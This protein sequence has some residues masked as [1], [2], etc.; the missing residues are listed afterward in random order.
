MKTLKLTLF[1]FA[2]VLFAAATAHATYS[3]VYDIY[4]NTSSVDGNSGYLYLQYDPTQISPAAS[5]ATVTGFTTDGSLGAQDTTDIVNG[6]A[7]S[8]TSLAN[9]N[10]AFKNTNGVND[11]EQAINFGSYLNLIVTFTFNSGIPSSGNGSSVFSLGIFADGAGSDPLF[12]VNDP[13]VP[14]TVGTLAL[15]NNGGAIGASDDQ[16]TSVTPI[17]PTVLLFGSGLLGL[18]GIRRRVKI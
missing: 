11:F 17:P 7:V 14:G 9:N 2:A 8:G 6:T 16:S 4:V 12:N 1:V 10:V 5:T 13:N 18:V 3:S 15:F